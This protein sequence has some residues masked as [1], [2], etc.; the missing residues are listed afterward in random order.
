[1]KTKKIK[2][3]NT[4][5]SI[6][7]DSGLSYV[8]MSQNPTSIIW[9]KTKLKQVLL[10]QFKQNWYYTIQN[11]SKATNYKIYKENIEFESYLDKLG[12]KN[13]H[14]LC[15]YR[16]LNHRLPIEVGRWNN[17]TREQRLRTLC[18]NDIGDEYHYI[19]CCEFFKNDRNLLIPKFF[20]NRSNTLKFKSLMASENLTKLNQ[21]CKLLI[22]IDQK[23][24]AP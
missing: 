10:D 12:N 5:K 2:W 24:S 14:R 13:Q 20:T 6:L 17:A 1:M 9:I 3:L 8:W 7:D 11:S 19:L 16:T 22:I 18:N 4:I 23:F 21:L 15:K